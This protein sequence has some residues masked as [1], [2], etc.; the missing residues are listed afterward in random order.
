MDSSKEL[1]DHERIAKQIAKTSDSIRK[2][3]RV[4][5]TGKINEDIALERYFQPIVEPLK[6]I[7]ENTI[8]KES[9]P[10]KKEVNCKG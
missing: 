8:G 1:K 4:L 7:V 2:K 10:I 9:Q 5:K 3:Y 6:Q